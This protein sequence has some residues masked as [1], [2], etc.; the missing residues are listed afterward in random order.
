M[1]ADDPVMSYKEM[2]ERDYRRF[3]LAEEDYDAKLTFSEY[4]NFLHPEDAPHMREV[5]VR[6]TMDDLDKN[7]DGS[8]SLEEYIGR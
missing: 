4:T 8:V 5:V 2:M 6:E 3:K 7:K 1:V